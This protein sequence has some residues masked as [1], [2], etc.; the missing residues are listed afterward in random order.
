MPTNSE[1]HFPSNNP[2]DQLYEAL[3]D[4]RTAASR[5]ASN[6]RA[7]EERAK[8]NAEGYSNL[9]GAHTRLQYEN[10]DLQRQV[11]ELKELCSARPGVEDLGD[12]EARLLQENRD[13][14]AALAEA[15]AGRDG[16]FLWR[17]GR[18]L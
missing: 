1:R 12:R 10:V 14:R 4:V 8:S 9:D 3:S 7:W 16:D 15:R 17:I 2:E 11:A 5:L 18:T 13:L 6:C